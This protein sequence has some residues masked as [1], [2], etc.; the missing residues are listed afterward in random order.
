MQEEL[1]ELRDLFAQLRADYARLQQEQAAAVP[2]PSA[3][4]SI[5][6]PQQTSS[7]SSTSAER[8]VLQC[9]EEGLV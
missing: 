7:T 4:P 8:L 1:R 2:G 9:F 6:D 5:P 3:V